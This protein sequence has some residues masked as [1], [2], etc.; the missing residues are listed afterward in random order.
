VYGVN[1]KADQQDFRAEELPD[2]LEED[3]LDAFI[4]YQDD[5]LER[6]ADELVKAIEDQEKMLDD[7]MQ[8]EDELTERF[9][10]K[11]DRMDLLDRKLQRKIRRLDGMLGKRLEEMD[12][13]TDDYMKELAE[14]NAQWRNRLESLGLSIARHATEGGKEHREERIEQK[15]KNR[16][17]EPEYTDTEEAGGDIWD[18]AGTP[19]GSETGQVSE[20]EIV[21]IDE[22]PEKESDE[23][24]IEERG[25]VPRK[26]VARKPQHRPPQRKVVPKKTKAA[27]GEIQRSSKMAPAY[28]HKAAYLETQRAAQR[29]SSRTVVQP[30]QVRQ[31]QQPPKMVSYPCPACKKPLIF[32]DKYQRWWCRSCKKWR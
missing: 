28:A 32:Y 3:K 21:I 1:G 20:E 19:A 11:E 12:R 7:L 4:R 14:K 30:K 15:Y 13:R 9:F 23:E 27:S 2:S 25:E 16:Y 31:V 18:E 8:K 29:R 5:V 10:L 22:G 6:N 26:V 24:M 17:Y